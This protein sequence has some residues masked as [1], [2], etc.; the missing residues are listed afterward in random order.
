MA[1]RR[2]YDSALTQ[3]SRNAVIGVSLNTSRP[4]S[5]PINR[6]RPT[7]TAAIPVTGTPEVL[8][9]APG[10]ATPKSIVIQVKPQY[11]AGMLPSEITLIDIVRTNQWRR[12]LCA[13][14][15]LG[16][17]LGWLK[18]YGR[19]DGLFWRIVPLAQPRPDEGLLRTNLLGHNQ[20]RGYADAHVR[21][22]DFSGEYDVLSLL[23]NRCYR[24]LTFVGVPNDP[25]K[26][27][28]SQLGLPFL[29]IDQTQPFGGFPEIRM[30]AGIKLILLIHI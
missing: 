27:G 17:L 6:V 16:E 30:A 15:T 18:P 4:A 29:P 28:R 12:P 10:T 21:V 19:P 14:I 7:T 8:G 1:G 23:I 25:V 11:A 20:Y 24:C 2:H 9:V 13:L 3:T 5:N 26:D 22:D